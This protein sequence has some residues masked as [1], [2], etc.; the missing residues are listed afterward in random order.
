MSAGSVAGGSRD[1]E[2]P[3]SPVRVGPQALRFISLF[4]DTA[5]VWSEEDFK[6]V[7]SISDIGRWSRPDEFVG[8]LADAA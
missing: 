4:D 2:D 6:L 1:F 8:L 5:D 3:Q 7:E